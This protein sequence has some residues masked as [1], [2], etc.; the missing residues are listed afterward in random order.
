[1]CVCVR[2]SS[3]LWMLIV[4]ERQQEVGLACRVYFASVVLLSKIIGAAQVLALHKA[5]SLKQMRRTSAQNR[6]V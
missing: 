3:K 2:C 5:V 6:S 4:T 1:M